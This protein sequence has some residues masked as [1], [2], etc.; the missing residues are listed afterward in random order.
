[1]ENF[2]EILGKLDSYRLESK[3]LRALIDEYITRLEKELPS[4][5]LSK[6]I[7]VLKDFYKW[8]V[9]NKFLAKE[10]V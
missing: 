1:M 9:M 2:E 10:E 3:E 6:E 4:D 7:E 8:V 5:I